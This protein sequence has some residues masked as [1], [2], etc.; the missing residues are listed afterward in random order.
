MRPLERAAIALASLALAFGLIALL[1]GFF[2]SHDQGS[3]S[4]QASSPGQNFPDQ[5][6]VALPP[7]ELRPP[8][9]SDPPTSGPHIPVQVTRDEVPLS[10]DQ[11]LTA[12]AEGDVVMM[13]GGTAPPPP[14]LSLAN[15]LGGKV[16][17]A[18][19]AAGQAVILAPRLGTSGVIA[20]AWTH[21]L[22]VTR[23]S[24]PRLREFA[25]VW[26][27]RGAPQG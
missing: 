12:L 19:I 14:L 10:N 26:L 3:L 16:T 7:G 17:P 11:L 21:M 20:L 24:D 23:A 6:N 2:N 1:S 4:G 13:Y 18:L 27:G 9:D 15:S 25:G 22:R 8:Y 5:G